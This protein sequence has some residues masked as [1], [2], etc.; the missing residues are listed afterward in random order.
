[1][2]FFP[3]LPYRWDNEQRFEEALDFYNE[4]VNGLFKFAKTEVDPAKK[5][6]IK[7]VTA[8]AISRAE[9]L[10]ELVKKMGPKRGGQGGLKL[11]APQTK[12]ELV[13]SSPPQQAQPSAPLEE[14]L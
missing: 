1:M 11:L 14:A 8:A 9:V 13:L 2:P 3:I 6:K 7:Q 5:S 10:K 12:R 4:A